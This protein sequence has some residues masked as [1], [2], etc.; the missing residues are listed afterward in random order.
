MTAGPGLVF[1][2]AWLRWD[3]V[4]KFHYTVKGHLTQRRKDAETREGGRGLAGV[5]L[6]LRFWIGQV[7]SLRI[8]CRGAR[9]GG[10]GAE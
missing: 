7:W 3:S 4:H 6:D 1:P 5:I 9:E 8:G 10:W 2:C